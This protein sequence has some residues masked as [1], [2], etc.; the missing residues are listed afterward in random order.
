MGV[1]LLAVI[2][3]L[4][5]VPTFSWAQSEK[6]YQCMKDCRDRYGDAGFFYTSPIT[7]G[8]LLFCSLE[9][10]LSCA[11][12][13]EEA[14]KRHEEERKR[15]EEDQKRSEARR[16]CDRSCSYKFK[17]SFWEAWKPECEKDKVG[18]C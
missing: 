11:T 14:K 15:S 5:V 16:A 1:K 17:N 2:V 3:A 7:G 4:L 18:G 8:G 6:R 10:D 12:R 9:K 13:M